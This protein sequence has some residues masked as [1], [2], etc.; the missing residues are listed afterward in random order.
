[1]ATIFLMRHGEAESRATSDQQ[2]RLTD[3][4]VLQ[5]RANVAKLPT[6][7]PMALYHSPL[8]R[9]EQSAQLL[10]PY[11]NC[12]AVHCV[13]WLKPETSVQVALSELLSVSA[14]TV[15]LVAHN[16]LLDALISELAG[17]PFGIYTFAT[18][19]LHEVRLDR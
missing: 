3:R 15:L 2:R 7:I 4:G 6:Q 9:A 10:I 13:D 18:G 11:L 16:P 12:Q 8:V 17:V 5:I 14:E 1:M 19:T